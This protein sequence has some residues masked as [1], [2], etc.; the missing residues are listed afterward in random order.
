MCMTPQQ[1]NIL[2]LSL[3]IAGSLI[4][5]LCLNKYFTWVTLSIGVNDMNQDPAS[6]TKVT[7]HSHH[8]D[9]AHKTGSAWTLSLIHI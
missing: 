8:V 3:N 6:D 1:L 9:R 5:A 4:V 2:G 7:G